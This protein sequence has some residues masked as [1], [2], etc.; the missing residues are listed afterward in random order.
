MNK[1]KNPFG[2][3]ATQKMDA[4]AVA[5][6]SIS[7]KRSN[8]QANA[9]LDSAAQDSPAYDASDEDASDRTEGDPLNATHGQPLRPVPR[10]RQLK[11]PSHA[12]HLTNADSDTGTDSP[13]YDGDIESSTN[14]VKQAVHHRSLLS[15][16][17]TDADGSPT[18]TPVMTPSASSATLH[19]PKLND[20]N[21]LHVPSASTPSALSPTAGTSTDTDPASLTIG[22]IQAFV[23]KAIDGETH[24]KYKI[25]RPPTDRPVRVYA[26]GKLSF[27]VGTPANDTLG[28]YDLFHFGSVI[29]FAR[30]ISLNDRSL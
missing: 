9:K 16:S 17:S 1:A 22:D 23:R 21:L 10:P 30:S 12:S 24:R 11:G 7:N 29:L 6:R 4:A 25:N 15:I 3:I 14:T 18:G 19:P 27:V 5:A 28:V 8:A 20:A 2:E 26:D 13:T